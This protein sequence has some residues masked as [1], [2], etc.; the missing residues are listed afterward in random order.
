MIAYVLLVCMMLS[1]WTWL[2][3]FSCV[4]KKKPLPKKKCPPLQI[5]ALR[6]GARETNWE[7]GGKKGK[8]KRARQ[9][10]SNRKSVQHMIKAESL[11]NVKKERVE[12][13]KQIKNGERNKREPPP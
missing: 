1:S 6:E 13:E 7:Q 11:R 5:F 12:N 3:K 8:G 2:K 10:A 9:K 4:P